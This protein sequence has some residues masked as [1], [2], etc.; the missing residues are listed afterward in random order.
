MGRIVARMSSS[1][2]DRSSQILMSQ[3]AAQVKKIDGTNGFQQT[4]Y[5][6]IVC[7]SYVFR[8]RELYSVVHL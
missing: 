2:V 3:S 5:T 4:L 7:A 8:K 1:Y 6:G